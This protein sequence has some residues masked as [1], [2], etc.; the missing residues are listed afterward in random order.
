MPALSPATAD[1]LQKWLDDGQALAM[2]LTP[3]LGS[4]MLQFL[5]QFQARLNGE[6]E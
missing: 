3:D 2:Q 6:N 1:A 5:S 4:L